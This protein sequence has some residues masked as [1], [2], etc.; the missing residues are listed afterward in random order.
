MCHCAVSAYET[1]IFVFGSSLSDLQTS[2][3]AEFF[4]AVEFITSL[5]SSSTSCL[6][7]IQHTHLQSDAE[8]GLQYVTI[9]SKTQ[10]IYNQKE[11]EIEGILW[12]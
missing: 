6:N 3:D 7:S 5:L 11:N 8:A 4:G 9:H 2:I 10:S 1:I 12:A